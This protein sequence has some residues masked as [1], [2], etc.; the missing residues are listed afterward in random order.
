MCI[1]STCTFNQ[2][3]LHLLSMIAGGGV[4]LCGPCSRN[5]RNRDFRVETCE[6]FPLSGSATPQTKRVDEII[7]EYSR[8]ISPYMYIYIYIYVYIY[9]Y[10]LMHYICICIM[11]NVCMCISLSLS[12]YIYIYIYMYIYIHTH[13]CIVSI[14]TPCAIV[15]RPSGPASC[16]GCLKPRL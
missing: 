1:Y 5:S 13:V 6:G 16:S 9:I 11:F 14:L 12:M 2:S 3:N 10:R 8:W 4:S 7:A 15:T